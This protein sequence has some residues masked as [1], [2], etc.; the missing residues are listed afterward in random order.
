MRP[1]SLWPKKKHKEAEQKPSDVGICW[2]IF[3]VTSSHVVS[4]THVVSSLVTVSNTSLKPPPGVVAQTTLT[5]LW[6]L[7]SNS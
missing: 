2:A 4:L 5:M 6:Q 3:S 7:R 1:A